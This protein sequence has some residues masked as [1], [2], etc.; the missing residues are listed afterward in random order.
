MPTTLDQLFRF[1]QHEDPADSHRV[2][3]QVSAGSLEKKKR[4]YRFFYLDAG[5]LRI[6]EEFTIYVQKPQ[7]LKG[8]F[9]RMLEVS[10]MPA[11][12]NGFRRT[13]GRLLVLDPWLGYLWALHHN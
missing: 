10:K 5:G 8:F 1:S 7:T 3:W 4:L 13:C 6:E 9:D 12:D 2:Q 11:L